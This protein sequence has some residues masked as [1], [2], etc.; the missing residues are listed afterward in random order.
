MLPRGQPAFE[1][2]LGYPEADL[3]GHP[4]SE[5]V[6]PDDV[7]A[8]PVPTT[9]SVVATGL[10]S[11][12]HRF[13]RLDGEYRW[14]SWSMLRSLRTLRDEGLLEFRRGRGVTVIGTSTH[15]ELHRLLGEL[16][17]TAAHLGYDKTDLINLIQEAT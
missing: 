3:E 6:H 9:A 10:A 11:F 15:G 13:R 7:S 1:A 8:K 4:V 2:A 14:L 12:E 16:I 17:R 5:F